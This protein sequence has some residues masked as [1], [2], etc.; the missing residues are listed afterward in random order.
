[1]IKNEKDEDNLNLTSIKLLPETIESIIKEFIPL[2]TLCFLNKTFYLN[3][4]KNVKKWIMSKNLYDNYIRHV[5]RNDNDYI[6]KL[7]LKENSMKWLRIK[8]YK[9]SNKIFGNYCC[10]IDKF[11][12]DHESTKCR[13]LLK[14]H[15][16]SISK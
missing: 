10:F 12:L 5:L 9:Y 4:R 14:K 6:F 16:I 8:K 1:M 7:L 3:Y 2:R 13:E 15:I 11:C